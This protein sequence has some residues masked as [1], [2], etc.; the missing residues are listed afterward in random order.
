MKLLIASNNKHKIE[1]I[2][3][4]LKD[5]FDKIFS[6][7]ELGIICNPEENGKTF[8]ENAL[9]KAAAV[10]KFTNFPVLADDTGLCVNALNGLPGVRSARYAGD[11]DHVKNRQKLLADM[12]EQTDRTAY[13]ETAVALLYPD[14]RTLTASGKVR[15]RIL[16]KEDG[17]NGFGY[18]SVFFCDELSKSFGK[19]TA[20]E[21]NAVSHRGRALQNLLEQI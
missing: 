6:L 4:I 19:A 17:T 5:K 7:E 1:E 16:E 14:G 10:A 9:I 2:K 13:F 12:L 20:E 15:G 3:T 11:H 18:D 21:K 8:L